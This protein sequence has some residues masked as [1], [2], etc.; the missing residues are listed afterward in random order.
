MRRPG[1]VLAALLAALLAAQL[2]MPGALHA[3]GG[4]AVE[5][6]DRARIRPPSGAV[7]ADY[8]N[9]GYRVRL[10][11]G[12]AVVEVDA[13]PLESTSPFAPPTTVPE[14]PESQESQESQV[15]RLA[16]ALTA[17]VTTRYA[18][19]SRILGWVSLSI[20]YDLDRRLP[21]DAESVLAR[22][23][24]YC[25]GVSRLTVALLTAA[26]I[27]A[28]EVAGYLASGPAG[29][30]FGD[31]ADGRPSGYHRWVE[32]YY[33]DRGWVFSDP[34]TS[35]HYV[36]ADH[37]R[38]ASDHLRLGR[39]QVAPPA[40]DGRLVAREDRIEVVDV[41]PSAGPGVRG[42]RNWGRQ[43]A[44]ALSVSVGGEPPGLAI[45]EGQ[46]R[47]LTHDLIG[48]ASAFVGLAPGRY[49]LRL[50]IAG[51]E[52]VRRTIEL[53]GA[54]RGALYLP[55]AGAAAGAGAAEGGGLR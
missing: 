30:R 34:L 54:V 32:V 1:L 24:G 55:P 3:A 15:G 50:L 7:V 22:R 14:G 41:Y 42:R 39:D 28:R 46:G 8:A 48:G 25:T 44:A 36:G 35:H 49:I 17:G 45:L 53:P 31:R 43:L 52:P 40:E 29:D 33:P 9:S 27:E 16:L 6:V 19:A 47:R 2:A 20:T 5:G 21:Q 12:E 18:A 10:E 38:L 37:L 51:R 23:T 13:A 4:L 11:G 26:G